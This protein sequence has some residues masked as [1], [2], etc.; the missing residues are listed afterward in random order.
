M[1]LQAAKY[2]AIWQSKNC[3][4]KHAPDVAN[5][6]AGAR[7][8][9]AKAS[10]SAAGGQDLIGDRTTPAK[11]AEMK[12]ANDNAGRW[13]S[14]YTY[15]ASEMKGTQAVKEY[16]KFEGMAKQI[17]QDQLRKVYGAQFTEKE[18]ERFFASMGLSPKMDPK[19]VG[20]C[21]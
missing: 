16:Q 21:S 6:N 1:R 3:E 8:S 11:I 12:K 7:V 10:A 19:F 5:I 15:S 18:G 14:D 13:F 17:V 9:A 20:R 4:Q 2:Q